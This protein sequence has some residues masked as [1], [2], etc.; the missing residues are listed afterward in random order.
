ML[1]LV[2][3]FRRLN[4]EGHLFTVERWNNIPKY[5]PILKTIIFEY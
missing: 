1:T 5:R 2:R 4:P 3:V